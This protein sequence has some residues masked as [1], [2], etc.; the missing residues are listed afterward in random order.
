MFRYFEDRSLVGSGASLACASAHQAMPV[1]DQ[2]AQIAVLR[3]WDP[4]PRKASLDQQP[5][6]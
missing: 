6:Q 1:P 5:E 4:D 2:L 3:T